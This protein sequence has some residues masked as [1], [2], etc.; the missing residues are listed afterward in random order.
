MN[1]TFA[2]KID[3]NRSA[4]G[5]LGAHATGSIDS[6]KSVFPPILLNSRQWLRFARVFEQQYSCP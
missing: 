1:R 5:A 2:S 3:R 6:G 4:G